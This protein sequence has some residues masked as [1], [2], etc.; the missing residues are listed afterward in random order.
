VVVLNATSATISGLSIIHG[1]EALGGGIRVQNGSTL[2]LF[3]STVYGNMALIG[4]G[5]EVEGGGTALIAN[6]I[7]AGNGAGLGGGIANDGALTVS[8]SLVSGNVA[9]SGGGGIAAEGAWGPRGRTATATLIDSTLA[10]NHAHNGAGIYVTEAAVAI[11][12]STSIRSNV[13]AFGGGIYNQSGIV[14]LNDGVTVSNNTATS[15]GGGGGIWTG[16][17]VTAGGCMGSVALIGGSVT[18][19]FSPAPPTINDFAGVAGC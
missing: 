11:H 15:P 5:I 17:G 8:H 7:V 14:E 18:D 12:G 19:N 4:G 10:E 9:T 3:G 1:N 13:A 2:S 16:R 6:S